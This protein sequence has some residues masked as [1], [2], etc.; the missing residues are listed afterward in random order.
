MQF[1]PKGYW[2]KDNFNYELATFLL[3]S[4]RGNLEYFE[5]KESKAIL[6]NFPMLGPK[7]GG[8][9]ANAKNK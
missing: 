2:K 9:C 3:T 6:N 1:L 5:K 8:D 4:M 7:K